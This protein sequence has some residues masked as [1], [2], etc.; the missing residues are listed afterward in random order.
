MR[1]QTSLIGFAAECCYGRAE[2]GILCKRTWGFKLQTF[3][4]RHLM[5]YWL[6]W[7]KNIGRPLQEII[8]LKR[9]KWK[10]LVD[11]HEDSNLRSTD[12]AVKYS[13]CRR[14]QNSC[15]Y[16]SYLTISYCLLFASWVCG[17][18]V[19]QMQ[20]F[21]GWNQ[22]PAAIQPFRVPI[23]MSCFAVQVRIESEISKGP[24]VWLSCS[25]QEI[26]YF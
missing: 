7:E 18:Q 9:V 2:R 22:T 21:F 15:S 25:S 23:I 4:N 26:R 13:T 16:F 6:S 5:L 19:I 11:F 1:I 10:F 8:C 17:Q 24:E 12:F 20:L 14:I 3:Q